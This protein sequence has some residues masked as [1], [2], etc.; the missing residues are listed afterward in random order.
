MTNFEYEAY[1]FL[2][3]KG[4]QQALLKGLEYWFSSGNYEFKIYPNCFDYISPNRTKYRFFGHIDDLERTLHRVEKRL[5]L[6]NIN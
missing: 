5:D 3:S 1:A 4:Y 2:K 6:N